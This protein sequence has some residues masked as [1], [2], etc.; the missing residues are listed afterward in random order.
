MKI[1]TLCLAL[2]L[3]ASAGV[4]QA[5]PIV[6][7]QTINLVADPAG[8]LS[9]GF[10]MTHRVAGLF[11]DYFEI[12]GVDGPASVDAILQTFGASKMQDIDFVSATING[13]AFEFS[14]SDLGDSLEALEIGTFP[15]LLIDGPL[16][17]T[18]TGRAGEGLADGRSIAATYSATINVNAVP[19]PG[20]LALA[21]LGLG[22]L[23]YLGR[24]RQR[25]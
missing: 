7:M 4:S 3:A 11:T 1:R 9:A 12:S 20:S 17:L 10:S 23:A 8:G 5:A 13:Y 6:S 22:A 14:K 24:R 16:R 25:A 19:E 15:E 21:G 18:I 2:L